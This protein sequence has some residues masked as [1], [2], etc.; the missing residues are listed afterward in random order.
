[1][2]SETLNWRH[3]FAPSLITPAM[4]EPEAVSGKCY[5]NG[6]D[7]SG[8]PILYIRPAKENTTTYD[9]QVQYF[10]F[11]VERAL[12]LMTSGVDRFVVIMDFE[13]YSFSSAP[14]RSTTIELLKIFSGHYPGMTSVFLELIAED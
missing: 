2:F 4:V 8:R 3:T 14:P 13:G 6:F 10:V 5:V 1:M 7:R 11:T 9:R 12:R